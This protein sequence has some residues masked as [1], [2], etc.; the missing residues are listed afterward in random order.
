MNTV[1]VINKAE[2]ELNVTVNNI[3]GNIQIIIDKKK[4][5]IDLLTL[6]EGDIFEINN[7]KYIVLEQLSGNQ[8]AILRKELLEEIMKF[9]SDNN[10]WKTSSIRRFLNGE[11]L[12]E[13]EKIFGRN[14]VVKHSVDLLSL[15][16]L[17]DYGT[18]IDD[19]SLLTV[20]EY[21]KYRKIL[22][23]NLD[24][25]WWLITPDSTP[26]GCSARC[27]QCVCSGGDVNYR[28][29]GWNDGGV[30]PFFILKS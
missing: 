17:D 15:D 7:V 10:N 6:K 18:S 25:W 30:R 11:Y 28:D 12:N 20:N 4:E 21:R 29:C 23:S 16:G 3:D 14:R 9:D 8:T 5:K 13:I 1:N 24:N 2:N 22:G 27:V 19:I 26:S